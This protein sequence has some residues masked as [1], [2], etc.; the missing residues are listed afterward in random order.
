MASASKDALLNMQYYFGVI[1]MTPLRNG[2][3]GGHE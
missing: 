3:K 2:T 1:F